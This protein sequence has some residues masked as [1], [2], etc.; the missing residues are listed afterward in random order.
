MSE[1]MRVGGLRVQADNRDLDLRRA[2]RRGNVRWLDLLFW[3]G[4]R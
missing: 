2:A 4:R 3:S 1:R